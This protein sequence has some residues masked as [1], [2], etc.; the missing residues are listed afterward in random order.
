MYGEDE[1]DQWK[2]AIKKFN[3]Y[4]RYRRTVV[5]KI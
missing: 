3:N 5:K 4:I 1:N 2:E